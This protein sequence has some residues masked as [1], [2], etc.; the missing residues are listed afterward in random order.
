MFLTEY[1]YKNKVLFFS[2]EL[3]EPAGLALA[4]GEVLSEEVVNINAAEVHGYLGIFAGI[5]ETL[6]RIDE[7]DGDL[8]GGSIVEYIVDNYRLGNEVSEVVVAVAAVDV[9]FDF[10]RGG[11]LFLDGLT[12]GFLVEFLHQ[13]MEGEGT[14]GDDGVGRDGG[15]NVV[16]EGVGVEVFAIFQRIHF[17]VVSAK[18]LTVF[19]GKVLGVVVA[20]LEAR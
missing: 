20:A 1:L 9:V 13:E 3:E 2:L 5:E 11:A 18:G 16:L 14:E 10:E 19:G 4:L 8:V 12:Q 17:S 7:T 15:R 6:G